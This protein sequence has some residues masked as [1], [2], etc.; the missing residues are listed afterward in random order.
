MISIVDII[1]Y[2][3]FLI[4][5][6]LFIYLLSVTNKRNYINIKKMLSHPIYS[7]NNVR[8]VFTNFNSPLLFLYLHCKHMICMTNHAIT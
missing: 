7:V 4:Y 5:I 1:D 6:Y 8:N 3:Y 2:F